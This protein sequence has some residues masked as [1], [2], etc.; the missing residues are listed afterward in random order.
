M[1]IALVHDYLKEMGGAERV[2]RVLSEMYPEAKIYTAF[3]ERGSRAAKAFDDRE[4]IE[5][6]WGRFLKISRFYSYFRFLLPF[7][8]RSIDLSDYELVISSCSGYIARGFRV[9]EKT[10]VVAYCHT[11]PK[12]L[13]GYETPTRAG[14]KWWGRLYLWLWGP[15]VRNF[16]YRAAERVDEWVAN[17][18]E[19]ARRINKFYRKQAK[20]IY[21]PIEMQE[22]NNKKREG[23]YLVVGRLVGSKGISLAYQACMRMGRRLMVVGEGKRDRHDGVEYTGW[24]SDEELAGLYERARGY[25]ALAK[26]EDFGMTVVEAIAHGTP[27]V[28][29]VSGGYKETVIEGKTGVRVEMIEDE[30]KQV[31][32]IV[33]GMKKL[34]RTKWDRDWMKKWADQF[35]REKFEKE[36]RKIVG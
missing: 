5:S 2:L 34:E 15:W 7:V 10:R 27:V 12:W 8:W 1:K 24:V 29:L 32:K 3:V 30:S 21:P 19:V 33:E 31:E 20:V 36:I 11:P 13:Y 17:S 4:I 28:G 35:G 14:G 22:I 18:E 23:Y 25:L 26:D 6:K 16:D 9:G